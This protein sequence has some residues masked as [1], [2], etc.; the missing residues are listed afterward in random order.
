VGGRPGIG[1]RRA[2]DPMRGH[3]IEKATQR[4]QKKGDGHALEGLRHTGRRTKNL[5][6]Y[7]ACGRGPRVATRPSKEPEKETVQAGRR[8]ERGESPAMTKEIAV[9]KVSKELVK[10][11]RARRS[12]RFRGIGKSSSRKEGAVDL[13]PSVTKSILALEEKVLASERKVGKVSD[14]R[15]LSS[16]FSKKKKQQ[17]TEYEYKERNQEPK[18]KKRSWNATENGMRPV[19]YA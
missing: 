17:Q 6:N 19:N 16:D 14:L 11:P 9:S 5:G 3:Y 15:L 7:H 10:T 2:A 13:T 8:E 18:L 12:S 1:D 4:L